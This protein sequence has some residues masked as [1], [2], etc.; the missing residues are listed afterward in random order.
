MDTNGENAQL[1]FLFP[2]FY[3][4]TLITKYNSKLLS[5]D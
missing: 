5:V 1:V 3:E 4:L 2:D